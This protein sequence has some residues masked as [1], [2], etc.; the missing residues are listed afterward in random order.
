MFTPTFTKMS[1]ELQHDVT[2]KGNSADIETLSHMLSHMPRIALRLTLSCIMYALSGACTV[3]A[4]LPEPKRVWHWLLM[5]L[6]TPR[7]PTSE[8][9]PNSLNQ[10]QSKLHAFGAKYGYDVA[11][12]KVGNV[13]IRRPA[14]PGFE[15]ATKIVI[16]SH[17][18]VVCSK[19]QDKEHNFHTDPVTPIIDG[20]WL[21]ADRTT[22]GADDGA[23]VAAALAILE[24]QSIQA[25][26]LEA[27]FTA[28]EETT[29][30]G[31]EF[32]DKAP[33][34]DSTV[35]IN[36]DSE[37]DH[38]ICVGCAGGIEK[39]VTLP[40][41]R[42]AAEPTAV[43]AVKVS[44]YGL[45]GGHTGIDIDKGRANALQVLV[46]LLE[47]QQDETGVA[48]QLLYLKGGNAAN[49]I[50]RDAEAVIAV[51]TAAADNYI[52]TLKADFAAMQKEFSH[53]EIKAGKALRHL[54]FDGLV[55]HCA[56]YSYIHHSLFVFTRLL[57]T[58]ACVQR[59]TRA[60]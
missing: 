27:V 38:E 21:R 39:T 15:K 58:C 60:A 46:R 36:V 50:P 56:T 16:Q 5:C 11:Q 48:G 41:T 12:D 57:S 25:G 13:R 3:F 35:L 24:D 8:A 32:M 7:P 33:F 26:Q 17:M 42:V 45:L 9:A 31:A 29:M 44:L 28:D 6:E 51:P 23:G 20:E 49:A 14:A 59:P 43:T 22:L 55:E 2:R 4:S 18:D 34:L 1:L 37:E 40:V 10:I 47:H 19:T 52:A 30:G 53:I 54:L